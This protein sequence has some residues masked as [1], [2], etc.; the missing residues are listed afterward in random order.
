MLVLNKIKLLEIIIM[1]QQF[2]R[3]I[4]LAD[5]SSK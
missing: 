2:K 5:I 4:P 3:P 1:I